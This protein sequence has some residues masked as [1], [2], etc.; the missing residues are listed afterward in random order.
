[1]AGGYAL[2]LF[3]QLVAAAIHSGATTIITRDTRV[4]ILLPTERPLYDFVITHTNRYGQLPS[5]ATLEQGGFDLPEVSDSPLFYLDRIF[6]RGHT[7][8]FGMP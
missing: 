4:D 3:D 8:R 1:M 6:L 5:V 2:S 7:Q